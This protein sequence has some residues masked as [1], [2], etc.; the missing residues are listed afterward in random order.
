MATATTAPKTYADRASDSQYQAFLK[1]DAEKSPGSPYTTPGSP[2]Y[3]TPEQYD[4]LQKYGYPKQF[5][6]ESGGVTPEGGGGASTGNAGIAIPEPTV[7][8]RSAYG[9]AGN[10]STGIATNTAQ[11]LSGPESANPSLGKRIYP[12]HMRALAALA[13]RV[14]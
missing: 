13:P 2:F 1:W 4:S 9:S 14:Y 10:Q 6:S 11:S 7:S 3:D 8:A 5:L 12:Q